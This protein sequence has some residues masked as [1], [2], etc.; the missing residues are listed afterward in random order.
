MA[1]SILENLFAQSAIAAAE[2]EE[3]LCYCSLCD[4]EGV[5]LS[6]ENSADRI[7]RHVREVHTKPLEN[8]KCFVG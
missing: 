4:W 1:P 3:E 7:A 8:Q 2:S 5:A 6:P